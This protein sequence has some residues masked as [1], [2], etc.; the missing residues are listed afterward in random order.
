MNTLFIFDST[1]VIYYQASGSVREPEGMTGYKMW[2]DVPEGKRVENFDM[3]G[4]T[5]VP[6]FID[7]PKSETQ[8]LRE[9]SLEIKLA[10]A[11]LAEIVAG[12]AA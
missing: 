4:E 5:P 12:G 11:E 10:L 6:M 2:V 1:G 8:I 3:T 9:E 7:M